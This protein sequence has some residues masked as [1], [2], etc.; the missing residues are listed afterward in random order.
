MK[1]RKEINQ[2][3]MI[4]LIILMSIVG[5]SG[6]VAAAVSN[7]ETVDDM[8]G[9]S[10]LIGT[11]S[12]DIKANGQDGPITVSSN[13]LVSI[14]I[15]LTAGI[16]TGA[17]ADWWLVLSTSDGLL[18][19]WVYPT[20]W[21]SGLVTGLQFPLI[22]FSGLEMYNSSLPVGN[23]VFYFGVDTTPDNV[24]NSP[25]VYDWVEVHVIN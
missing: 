4:L 24:L 15:D 16:Q 19:S 23:Y 25:L 14:T 11:V 18:Y 21:T 7:I 9:S 20:G 10:A 3:W 8:T 22:G 13:S 17:N 6:L 1:I 2:S 12:T 5:S